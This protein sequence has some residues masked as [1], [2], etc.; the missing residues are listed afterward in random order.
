MLDALF[1]QL[2]SEGELSVE[3]RR[4]AAVMPNF[5]Y[6]MADITH[7][8]LEVHSSWMGRHVEFRVRNAW[9]SE[10]ENSGWHGAV[11]WATVYETELDPDVRKVLDK[12]NARQMTIERPS[13]YSR[14]VSR[15][16]VGYEALLALAACLRGDVEEAKGTLCRPPQYWRSGRLDINDQ[17]PVDLAAWGRGENEYLLSEVRGVIVERFG[18]LVHDDREL[19]Q[20]LI[21][22]GVIAAAD[23]RKDLVEEGGHPAPT[24]RSSPKS[25]RRK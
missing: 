3:P 16:S 11:K 19:I 24:Q 7:C 8:D 2:V 14:R 22:E 9:K 12:G 25:R 15:D 13:G 1:A 18:R 5:P 10:L 17:P 6:D 4:W 23:A 21:D 20:V